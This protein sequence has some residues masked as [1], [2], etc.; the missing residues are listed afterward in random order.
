LDVALLA[1]WVGEGADELE[2]E[3]LVEEPEEPV[4]ETEALVGAEEAPDA[5]PEGESVGV[6]VSVTPTAAQS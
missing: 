3:L 2:L 5:D 1:D 6:E 4:G